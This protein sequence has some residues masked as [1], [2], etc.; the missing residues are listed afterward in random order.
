[1]VRRSQ[2]AARVDGAITL[3][4][5]SGRGDLADCLQRRWPAADAHARCRALTPSPPEGA[6]CLLAGISLTLAPSLRGEGLE[7]FQNEDGLPRSGGWSLSDR[8]GRQPARAR[9][10]RRRGIVGRPRRA[11]G[12]R[13]PIESEWSGYPPCHGLYCVHH[14]RGQSDRLCCA[15]P[16]ATR[17]ARS[18]FSAGWAGALRGGSCNDEETAWRIGPRGRLSSDDRYSGYRSARFR[19]ST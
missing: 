3:R 11:C 1:M 7:F 13:S 15:H 2:V 17:H 16:V 8:P 18:R 10:G 12:S 4:G 19:W 9:M 6:A 14:E 5:G